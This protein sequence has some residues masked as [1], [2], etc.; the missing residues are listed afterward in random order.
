MF[1]LWGCVRLA[2]S[3]APVIPQVRRRYREVE[4]LGLGLRSDSFSYSKALLL[5]L[6]A[7]ALDFSNFLDRGTQARYLLILVPF[8]ALFW[9]RLNHRSTRIRTPAIPDK[10]L[11]VLMLYALIGSVWGK[12]VGGVPDSA[13]SISLPMTTALLY[14]GTYQSQSEWEARALLR[15]LAWVGFLYICLNAAA[16]SGIAPRLQSSLQYRNSDIIYVAMGFAAAI[17]AKQRI[18]LGFLAILGAVIFL[19]YPSGTTVVVALASVITMYMTRPRAS[20]KRPYKVAMVILAL[21]SLALFNFHSS[22]RLVDAYFSAVHKQNN[23]QGRI[24]LWTEG[25]SEFKNS[26]VFGRAFAG[27]T[28]VATTRRSGLGAP[29]QAPLHNDYILFLVEGGAVGFLLLILWAGATEVMILRRHRAFIEA[30]QEHHAALLRTLLVGFNGYFCAAAF[31]PLFY[32]ASRSATLFAIYGLM[33][34]LGAPQRTR[35]DGEV[36]VPAPPLRPVLWQMRSG[37][38]SVGPMAP[39]LRQSAD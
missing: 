10:I 29:I 21:M 2:S 38:R 31:N 7:V 28:T 20:R 11:L 36:G 15:M 27:G 14:L 16:N 37:R 3:Q 33:M 6:V 32:G 24:A 12:V 35:A 39:R 8:L 25:L 9:V 22:I 19:G 4:P 23:S 13:L 34:G 5:I 17:N 1:A 18:R 26:P 30:G